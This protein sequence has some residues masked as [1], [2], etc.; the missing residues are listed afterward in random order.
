M[1]DRSVTVAESISAVASTEWN[2][3]VKRA[4]G[5]T[6]YQ[7]TGWIGAAEETFDCR[8][9]H[10]VVR[11]K[12]SP[13][14]VFPNLATPLRLPSAVERQLPETFRDRFTE[15]GSLHP[16]YG[17]PAIQ[18]DEPE[19]LSLLLDAVTDRATASDAVSHFVR[20]PDPELVRYASGFDAAGYT[21]RLTQ[22]RL[23]L[24]LTKSHETL[25]AEMNRSK[26]RN[27]RKAKEADPTV[28]LDAAADADLDAFYEGYETT[29]DRVEAEPFPR[30]FFEELAARLG[31]RVQIGRATVDGAVV[32]R[33]LYLCDESADTLRHEFSAVDSDD[34]EHYPS[35]LIHDH[36]MQWASERGYDTYDF[37]STPADVSDGLFSY[38]REFGGTIT[39]LVVYER[40]TSPLWTAYRTARAAYRRVSD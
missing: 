23:T 5:G 32:G 2:E 16:G 24:D 33:H 21:P 15:L 22:C 25:I 6:I 38:K 11:K 17:G 1:T 14:G 37:G 12:G 9:Q 7:T 30:Q 31:D 3:V 39:P 19:T 4:D 10:A 34:F 13:V 20:L 40:G 36:A 35:E 18:A 27:L 26:R 8:G 29:M 28:E